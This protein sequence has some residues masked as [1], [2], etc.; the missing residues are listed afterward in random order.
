VVSDIEVKEITMAKVRLRLDELTGIEVD[1]DP[2]HEFV[3]LARMWFMMTEAPFAGPRF[4]YLARWRD[5]DGKLQFAVYF[6]KTER[7][8]DVEFEPIETRLPR[9]SYWRRCGR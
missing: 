3:A 4:R 9:R 1:G 5:E 6:P 2:R 8:T 7:W